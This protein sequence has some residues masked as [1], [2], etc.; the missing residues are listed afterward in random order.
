M[1]IDKSRT[2]IANSAQ[3]TGEYSDGVILYDAIS[4]DMDKSQK[5]NWVKSK[6]VEWQTVWYNVTSVGTN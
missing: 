5:T 3:Y 2:F 6:I 4:V 1:Y